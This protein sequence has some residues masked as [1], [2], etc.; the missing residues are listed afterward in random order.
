MCDFGLLK[1]SQARQIF[2]AEVAKLAP[3]LTVRDYDLSLQAAFPVHL[4]L[5]IAQEELP[6]PFVALVSAFV[7]FLYFLQTPAR[8]VRAMEAQKRVEEIWSNLPSGMKMENLLLRW[9]RRSRYFGH[10]HKPLL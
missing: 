5:E 4:V 2:V 1:S 6:K 3:A 7:D 8:T 10:S 9:F